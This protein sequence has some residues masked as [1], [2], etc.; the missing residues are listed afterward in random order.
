MNI[1]SLS[2]RKK[3]LVIFSIS[4][5]LLLLF[6]IIE[7]LARIVDSSIRSVEY[8][9]YNGN[10]LEPN[11]VWGV[12]HKPNT[13]VTHKKKCFQVKYTSNSFGMRDIERTIPKSKYRIAIL[14]DSMVEG[15]AVNDNET[16]TRV[17][18]DEIYNNS[19]EVLNFGTS[20]NF[21]TTQQF[22]LFKHLVRKFDPDL[23]IL[24]FFN[25]ND[26]VDNSLEIQK[27]RNWLNYWRRPF[28]NKSDNNS[29]ELKYFNFG[30]PEKQDEPS[31]KLCNSINVCSV[32]Y[33]KLLF[34]ELVGKG[35]LV[36]EFQSPPNQL[37]LDSWEKT[38]QSIT[39]LR[40]LVVDAG[41]ELIVFDIPHFVQ[42]VPSMYD[43]LKT[44]LGYDPLEPNRRLKKIAEKLSIKYYFPLE[45]F[46]DFRDRNHVTWPYF[47]H[48]CDAHWT[49]LGHR[50]AAYSLAQ[51]LRNLSPFFT[52]QF[53]H[54]TQE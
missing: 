31:T 1:N 46:E 21:G 32:Q 38:N 9:N 28:L 19:I 52:Y 45:W 27:S 17:L 4:L 25:A 11:P 54:L 41:S 12:W 14:G 51:Y 3:N 53:D 20:G 16:V 35:A 36:K 37:Y 48:T 30:N 43:K 26:L 2:F 42:I 6:V 18:E 29:W 15:Y 49:K 39:Q 47:S 44:T 7:I 22:L 50:V 5:A 40:D 34:H 23:V 8:E 10:W 13:S 24:F 33:L